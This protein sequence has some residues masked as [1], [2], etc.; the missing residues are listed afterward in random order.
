MIMR[1]SLFL[2]SLLGFAMLSSPKFMH[3]QQRPEAAS[4]QRS[5]TAIRPGL[6]S[7]RQ[8]TSAPRPYGEVITTKAVSDKGMFTVHKVDEKHYFEIPDSLLMREILVINR[9]SKAPAGL[10]NSTL[11]YAGDQLSQK[12]V[13]FE[14]GPSNKLFLRTIS[15][16]DFAADSTSAMFRSV[17]NSNLQPISAAFDIKAFSKDST[18]SVIE[19][20][21][22]LNGDNDIF[23]LS[24]MIKSSARIGALQADRSY[25]TSVKAFPTN[26]EVKAIKSF[27]MSPSSSAGG[28]SG[29]IAMAGTP[30]NI[31]TELNSSWL[32]LPAK[33]M[34][35]RYYDPRVG[36]F[37][38]GYTDYDLNP[39]G[40]KSV[41]LIKRWRLEPKP[42]DMDR[43]LRGEL[44]DPQK[45]I[46]FYIDPTTPE[47]W[48]PYLIQG[49]DDWQKSFEK[50]GFRNAI[51][52]RR[53]PTKEENPDW[54][55]EDARHSAIVYKPSTTPNA[56]GPSIADPRSGEIMESHI[57]WYHN[58]MLL[59]RNW[60]F[61]Q[62]SPNDPGARKMVFE[63][64][65]MGQLIR[66]VS[67]HEVGHTLGLRHNFGASA[68]VPVEKLR[69]KAWVEANGH[70]P[71]IMDYA[72]FNYVAQ[73]E[74]GVSQAGIFPRIGPYDDWAIEWGYRRFAE[75]SGPQQEKAH[76]NRLVIQRLK[77]KRLWFGDGETYR[78]DPR[79]LTEQVGDDAVAGSVY[80]IRNLQRVVPKLVE[81]TKE[82]TEG[83]E[84]L[85]SMY[86]E[87][88]R[89]FDRY[90]GHV[91]ARIGGVMRTPRTVDETGPVYEPELKRKQK[92]AV[93]HLNRHLFKTPTWLLDQNIFQKTGR[94]GLETLGS[95]QE[96]ALRSILR[97]PRLDNMVKAATIGSQNEAYPVIE[98]LDD[99]KSGIWTE[100]GTSGKIDVYRRQLQHAYIE[101][102][103]AILNPKSSTPTGDLAA[104]I[105]LI[106][107]MSDPDGVDITGSVRNHLKSLKAD[108]SRTSKTSTDRI[109][110]IHLEDM[111]RRID[112]ALNPNK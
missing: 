87:V 48:I 32:L 39:Q 4:S 74:D 50:A 67:S 44:V 3:A 77:D 45:P 43:Y 8:Q 101:R 21:D 37:A 93:Q 80:G 10:Q 28:L 5:D 56:S 75:Y 86:G 20:T 1:H 2:T 92:E 66:F 107:S 31:T 70:T 12:V 94:S 62:A 42:E 89:Q 96:S 98:L 105:S 7:T 26:V 53:A 41:S 40:V 22:L 17:N 112:K 104:I 19:T 38:V 88:V 59:L 29:I 51:Q 76:L 85:G 14:K 25:L 82:P 18:S 13:R 9:V 16:A 58:V 46:V 99:L 91:I 79:N 72:R 97:R 35:A 69:D 23:F 11:N 60:Y 83:Y 84:E 36:Y 65:L 24:N 103:D 90:N 111:D 61:I 108:V 106:S 6:P 30:P 109:T 63:D 95:L 34:Q 52:G 78:E 73:P 57:N 100:L 68:S 15:Y 81:W 49:V 71:S 47:K 110:R 64:T 33:P 27:A 54:S 102:M 55:L